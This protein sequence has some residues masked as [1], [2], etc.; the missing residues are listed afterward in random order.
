MAKEIERFKDSIYLLNTS[1]KLIKINIDFLKNR[2]KKK[3]QNI[4]ILVDYGMRV[5]LV[6]V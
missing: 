2:I 5:Y 6:L 1:G 3:Q 4:S